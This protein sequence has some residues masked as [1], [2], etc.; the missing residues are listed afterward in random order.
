MFVVELG[1]SRCSYKRPTGINA[2]YLVSYFKTTLNRYLV[3]RFD[4]YDVSVYTLP[5]RIAESDIVY[6]F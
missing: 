4:I 1:L 6:S 5:I 2:T 3:S